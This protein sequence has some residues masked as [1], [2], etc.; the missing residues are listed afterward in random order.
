MI[1]SGETKRRKKHI[2]IGRH[3]VRQLAGAFT[4]SPSR[5][6]FV[7]KILNRLER[8]QI[9]DDGVKIVPTD[10]LVKAVRHRSSDECAVRTL[11]IHDHFLDLRI[12]VLAQAGILVGRYIPG[13]GLSPG[14]PKLAPPAPSIFL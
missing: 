6:L 10:P 7:Y 2:A 14:P 13:N 12:V 1:D 9:G 4:A 3:R 11:A 5:V 8:S